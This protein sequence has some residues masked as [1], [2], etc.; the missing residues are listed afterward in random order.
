MSLVVGM[1]LAVG[2]AV[3]SELCFYFKS[4]GFLM[5]VGLNLGHF[6]S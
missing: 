5:D 4:F 2:V 6:D 3:K 1:G